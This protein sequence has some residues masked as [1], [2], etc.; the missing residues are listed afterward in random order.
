MP[1]WPLLTNPCFYN[2]N[3]APSMTAECLLP[4]RIILIFFAVHVYVLF[5]ILQILCTV[6]CFAKIFLCQKWKKWRVVQLLQFSPCTV[7]KICQLSENR[8]EQ[9]FCRGNFL[10]ILGNAAS[11]RQAIGKFPLQA[12][13]SLL[14]SE[15]FHFLWQRTYV[16]LLIPSG[17]DVYFSVS[18]KVKKKLSS[19]IVP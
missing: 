3:V 6:A 10:V 13:C 12:I 14:F 11:F 18:T 4:S 19:L 5:Y 1:S 9:V 2:T 16:H 7:P 17:P 15:I 8:G